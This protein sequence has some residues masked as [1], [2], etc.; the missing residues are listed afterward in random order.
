MQTLFSYI[1]LIYFSLIQINIIFFL[2]EVL[3]LLFGPLPISLHLKFLQRWANKGV[4][5]AFHFAQKNENLCFRNFMSAN[6]QTLLTGFLLFLRAV[7]EAI[8]N[9]KFHANVSNL[10]FRT[11]IF[12]FLIN[13]SLVFRP[14][15]KT[16]HFQ[17]TVSQKSPFFKIIVIIRKSLFI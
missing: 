8:Y 6:V 7:L 1:L 17:C 9:H 10:I 4:I 16:K 11:F 13:K 5:F 15:P 14:A 2:N 12:A 3:I